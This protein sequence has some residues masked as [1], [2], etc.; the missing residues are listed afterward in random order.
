MPYREKRIYSG[1]LLEIQ[2]LHCTHAGRIL[3]GARRMGME[4]SDAQ[5][6]INLAN[7]RRKL[8]RWVCSNFTAG[9]YHITLT[10]EGDLGSAETR[11]AW[12]TQFLRRLRTAYAKRGIE[13]RYIC[14]RED[15]G[16][17]PHYHVL[18][19]KA[20]LTMEDI[21]QMWGHGRVGMETMD[22]NPDY[23]WLARYLTKQ[24]EKDKFRKRWT[25]SRNLVRPV[26]MPPRVLKR[27]HLASR[28]QVPKGY[29]ILASYRWATGWGYEGEYVIA[30]RTD[31]MQELPPE[32]QR[33]LMNDSGGFA[34]FWQMEKEC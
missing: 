7:A 23:G 16:V 8:V 25:Q 3:G 31:R 2:R 21:A 19:P 24:D 13:L 10:V 32:V 28:P 14:V 29:Y 6:K 1:A 5:K 11:E 22:G 18:V 20:G 27:K 26:E 30:I 12:R 34:E 33:L 9:D 4:T 15:K 17:R